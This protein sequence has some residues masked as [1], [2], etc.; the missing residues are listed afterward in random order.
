MNKPI[1]TLEP[2]LIPPKDTPVNGSSMLNMSGAQTKKIVSG[3][4]LIAG[5]K[6]STNCT[7]VDVN[8]A[9]EVVFFFFYN[10]NNNNI[11]FFLA[12]F[13]S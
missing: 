6:L 1:P 7:D 8:S 4:K 9:V 11:K 5:S 12:S 13:I 2:T 3:T 10:K